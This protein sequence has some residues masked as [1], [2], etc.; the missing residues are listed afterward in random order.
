[1]ADLRDELRAYFD[2]LTDDVLAEEFAPV[3]K[4]RRPRG[5]WLA[6]AAAVVVI[7]LVAAD[8]VV[9][10]DAA[11]DK[12]QVG[13][14][15]RTLVQLVGYGDGSS[16][17][18]LV[19]ADPA[20]GVVRRIPLAGSCF[21]HLVVLDGTIWGDDDDGVFRVN[22]PYD[23]LQRVDAG[24]G[25]LFRALDGSGVWVAS[26]SVGST[27]VRRIGA[28][29]NDVGRPIPIPVGFDVTDPPSAVVG[30]ILL[31]SADYPRTLLIWDPDTKATRELA[32]N[33]GML[34]AVHTA[35]G[36]H[37]SQVMY[38]DAHEHLNILDT[39]TGSTIP[40]TVD[41]DVPRSIGGG[42]FSPDGKTVAAFINVSSSD[43]GG[44]PG[45]RIAQLMLVDATT[46]A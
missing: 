28:K 32:T 1:M 40:I 45:G 9:R 10:E 12:V 20:T 5:S 16:Y 30:G 17:E 33:V 14:V 37:S 25:S 2:V 6:V 26:G 34:G 22:P 27:A 15:T 35:P 29:T 8:V 44:V 11:D 39:A 18:D 42:A 19:F 43:V 46:G 7:A 4:R 41:G 23:E 21:C 31:V 13:G 38:R 24:R 3:A 36:A